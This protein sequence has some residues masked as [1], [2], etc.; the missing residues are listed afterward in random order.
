MA[1]LSQGPWGR[2]VQA[3]VL[4]AQHYP[5]QLCAACR[6]AAAATVRDPKSGRCMEI[7]TTAPGM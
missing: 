6:P 1:G 5:F 4:G 7:L 2:R 3:G